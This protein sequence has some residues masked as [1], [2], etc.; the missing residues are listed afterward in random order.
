[1]QICAKLEMLLKTETI[2]ITPYMTHLP[3]NTRHPALIVRTRTRKLAKETGINYLVLDFC[4]GC[5]SP[6]SQED[7][8]HGEPRCAAAIREQE[9]SNE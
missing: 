7:E 4:P 6:T 3:T 1:M 5:G 2:E 9:A 8:T